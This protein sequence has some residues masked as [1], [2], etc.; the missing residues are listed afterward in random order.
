LRTA[1]SAEATEVIVT[2]G[3]QA[4]KVYLPKS[5]P[6]SKYRYHTVA[7]IADALAS[8][9]AV[10]RRPI[11]AIHLEASD[12]PDDG[13]WQKQYR[14]SSFSSYMNAGPD[15]IIEV[16]PLTYR[17]AH[18]QI[19][20]S[21]LHETGH[22]LSEQR[23][24]SDGQSRW[25][26]D[27]RKAMQNDIIFPSRYAMQSPDDDFAETLSLYYAIQG[28]SQEKELRG[29]MPERFRILDKIVSEGK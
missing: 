24:S 25:W 28:R 3:E 8:L 29:L 5:S 27:W 11:T 15:G 17:I 4:I 20:S 13:Y 12:N 18:A 14:D 22:I 6:Q 7:E 1:R 10:C 2:V 16:Y 21:M 9:P 23:W 19:V 26:K